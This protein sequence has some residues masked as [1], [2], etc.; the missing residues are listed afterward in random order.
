MRAPRYGA[1]R[2]GLALAIMMSIGVTPCALVAQDAPPSA[3]GRAHDAGSVTNSTPIAWLGAWSPLRPVGEIARGQLRAPMGPGLLLAPAPLAG[4]FVLAGAPGSLARDLTPRAAGDTTRWS[5]FRATHAMES[6][7][8]RRPLD[9][10]D[11]AATQASGGG[12]SPVGQRGVAMGRFVVDQE[13]NDVSSFTQRV[14]PYWSSPFVVTDSVRPPMVRTRARLEGALGLRVAGFGVGV[15][16]GLDAREHVSQNFP[17]RRTGR[18]AVPATSLGIER[19]LPWAGLRVGAYHRWTEPTETNLLNPRPLATI[20]YA[21]QGLAEPSGILV[22]ASDQ[23]FV[24]QDRRATA[25]GGTIEATVF[26]ARMV[27]T[28]ESGDRFDDEYRLI[29]ARVRPTDSWRA[30][31]SDTRVQLQRGFG[32]AWRSTLVA[33][34]ITING[35]GVRSDLRGVAVRGGDEQ[36]AVEADLRWQRRGWQAGVLGGAMRRTYEREDFVAQASVRTERATPFASAEVARRWSTRA[37]AAGLSFA[38]A[39]PAG[40]VPRAADQGPNY[41]RLIAPEL[42]YELAT[43]RA[44]S[45]WITAEQRVLG[46]AAFAQARTERVSPQSLAPARLQPEGDR[47]RWSVSVGFR[48]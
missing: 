47:T 24:R 5:E 34:R 40:S 18:W 2:S 35:S 10:V 26:G 15:S 28:H 48:P 16:A 36:L 3:W 29:T 32:A 8:F 46:T 38:T 7:T 45:A 12:W 22:T 6:G 37:V 19:T 9:A 44:W 41:R 14:S 25:L 43:A 23:I 17:L 20:V 39:S 33:H 1:A 27:V 30:R 21:V 42:A 13:R 31:A 11:A 4:A